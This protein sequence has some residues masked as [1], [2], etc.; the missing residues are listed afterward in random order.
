M[1]TRDIE[2][3][4]AKITE[5]FINS[6][7]L[8]LHKFET[9]SGSVSMVAYIN[10]L[11][12]KEALNENII[13]PLIESLIS[14]TDIKSTLY[15]TE[16]K[17]AHNL[18]EAVDSI[19]DGHVVL[20]NEELEF[21][22]ILNI[23]KYER[24][25]IVESSSEQVIR[26]SKE[27]FVEDLFVNRTLIRRRV[28]NKNLVFEDYV[29]GEQTN[30]KVSIVY[31]KGI[32]NE[33]ILAELK[34]RLSKIK[35]DAIL[36]SYYIEEYIEDSPNSLIAT[37][38]D[39]E[40]PDVLA[41]KILEGRIGIICDGS[42]NVLTLP[43][44]F[45]ENLMTA[46]DYY[47]R[48]QFAIYLRIIRLLALMVST[49]LI[50]VYIALATF[51]QGMIPTKLLISISS[52]RE[53]TPFPVLLEGILMIL[54]FEFL[55]EAGLRLPKPLG[56]TVT[57]VGGLVIGQAAV[58]AGLVSAI[59]II[60]VSASGITEFVNPQLREAIV[61]YRIFFLVLGG[62]VGLYGIASGL[63]IVAFHLV[64]IKSFGVPYMYPIAPYDK[65][66]MKDFINRAKLK[67]FNYRPKYIANKKASKRSR[68]DEY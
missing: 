68:I 8:V 25:S 53:G 58:D 14:P 21:A 1:I 16:M 12:D 32:V 13:K 18:E 22:Y 45:I 52:Q 65:E 4:K 40:K 34:S 28:R 66:G 42:P 56:A 35:A 24:R 67:K 3:N 61:V 6:A 15:I 27:S 7:D 54:F 38:Y 50:G 19:T 63:I 26:G 44:V 36:D 10:G 46:E 11:V 60:I 9:L 30:T 47:L 31:I 59:M 37:L 62:L 2:E 64:S 5:L 41:G 39:T 17:E 55:K 20:F 43:M 23:C 57:L 51:H 48:S 49:L 29:F 33:D